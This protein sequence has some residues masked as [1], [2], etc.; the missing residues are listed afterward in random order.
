MAASDEYR[1]RQQHWLQRRKESERLFIRIGN[2][3]LALGITEAVLAYLVFGS[4]Q[5]RA[6]WLAIPVVVFIFLAVWQSRVIRQRTC[7]D[8][9][10]GFYKRALA[11][12]DDKWVGTG[13]SG[14]RFR[15][16]SHV[17]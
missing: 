8:R 15:D 11:R 10:L 16:S 9:A 6:F 4:G 5:I 7:A 1:S 2:A 12:L 14:E 17:Y 13:S 3:R